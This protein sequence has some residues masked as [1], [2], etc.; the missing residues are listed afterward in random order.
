MKLREGIVYICV[1]IIHIMCVYI[2]VYSTTR[3]PS[4]SRP[5]TYSWK[6]SGTGRGRGGGRQGRTMS[7]SGNSWQ[8]LRRLPHTTATT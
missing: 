6:K 7:L 2:I 4:P 8:R 1:Y 5:A 3:A